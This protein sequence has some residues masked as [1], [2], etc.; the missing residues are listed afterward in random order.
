MQENVKS[1]SLDNY[2]DFESIYIALN[3]RYVFKWRYSFFL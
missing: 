3:F 2:T 1:K